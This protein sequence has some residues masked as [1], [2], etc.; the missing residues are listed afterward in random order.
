MST[1]EIERGYGRHQKQ[2]A[3]GS[4]QIGN[5]WPIHGNPFTVARARFQTGIELEL[6]GRRERSEYLSEGVGVHGYEHEAGYDGIANQTRSP[7]FLG[8]LVS[9][10]KQ[11]GSLANDDR[12]IKSPARAFEEQE[13]RA[14]PV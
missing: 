3:T 5:K 13:R 7:S 12:S 6:H 9:M 2:G 10:N 11:A 8:V 14:P 4:P 1:Q